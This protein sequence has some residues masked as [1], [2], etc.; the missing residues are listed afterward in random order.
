MSEDRIAAREMNKMVEALGAW[1]ISQEIEPSV[2]VSVMSVFLAR[3]IMVN[4]PNA[5]EGACGFD[6]VTNIMLQEMKHYKPERKL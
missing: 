3:L 5:P 4:Q 1:F 2:A 6:F